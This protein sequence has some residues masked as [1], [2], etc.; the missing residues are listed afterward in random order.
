MM[1]YEE[2]KVNSERWFD[3]KP[4]LNEEFRDIVGYEGKYQVSNYGRVKSLERKVYRNNKTNIKFTKYREKI[5]LQVQ[6]GIKQNQKYYTVAI[7]NQGKRRDKK[8]HILVAEVFLDKNDFK[9]MLDED[10]KLINLKKLQVNHKDENSSNNFVE[11]LEWCTHKYNCN[12][13]TRIERIRKTKL[14]KGGDKE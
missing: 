7:Y 4:L 2:V 8:V 9:S 6:K 11:N 10:R 13:G 12:Y 1:K 5:L 3:L 14:K